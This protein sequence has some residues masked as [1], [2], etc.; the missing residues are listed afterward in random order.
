MADIFS[1]IRRSEIMSSIKGKN[2][3]PELRVRKVLHRLGFRFRLHD[4]RLP[5]TPD[6]VLKKYKTVIFVNGCFWHGHTECRRGVSMPKSRT[7]FW[8]NKISNNRERDVKKI[9]ELKKI[10]WKVISVFECE[11]K[12]RNIENTINTIHHSLIKT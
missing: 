3:K 8:Q 1:S 10:G 7:E 11:L 5:G 4:K 6:I 12:S 2:T 9:E